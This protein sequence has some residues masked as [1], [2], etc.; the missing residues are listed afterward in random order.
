MVGRR[1]VRRFVGL[2]KDWDDEEKEMGEVKVEEGKEREGVFGER[3]KVW[4]AAVQW[5]GQE[6]YDLIKDV[7]PVKG[8]KRRIYTARLEREDRDNGCFV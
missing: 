2:W 7:G 8:S 5:E 4:W 1:R 6:G 3:R